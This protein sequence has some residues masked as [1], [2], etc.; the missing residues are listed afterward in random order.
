[1]ILH[2]LNLANYRA[3]EQIEIEF[4]SDVTVIAGVNGVG[5]S[6]IL[7]AIAVM[8]SRALPE[9][10]EA[11]SNIARSF[12]DDD[13][14]V[15]KPS[16]EVSGIFEVNGQRF[17]SLTQRSLGTQSGDLV[18]QILEGLRADGQPPS[19]AAQ[20]E[21]R[22]TLRQFKSASEQPVAVLF[23]PGRLLPGKPVRLHWPNLEDKSRAYADALAPRT[24]ELREFMEWFNAQQELAKK[25]EEDDELDSQEQILEALQRVVTDFVPEFTN[26]RIEREPRLRFVVDKNGT[27]LSL[28][29]L[30]DG[31]RGLLAVFFDLT[32]R[33]TIANP[34]R[35]DPI[36]DG[37]GIV[38][39]DEIE[40]HL[41]PRWQR[42][43][44][45]KLKDTFAGCQFILTTHSPQTLGEAEARQVRYLYRDRENH[46]RRIVPSQALGLDSS[47][48]LE[49]VMGA[50][51]RNAR[52]RERL[53]DL[54]RAIDKEEFDSARS[55]Y[56]ELKTYIGSIDPD[57]V[58][59]Q[60]MMEFLGESL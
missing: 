2:K 50:P 9:F 6:A 30:S 31:E 57:L 28:N 43:A 34:D 19:D 45:H 42:D 23:S 12:N 56:A 29:Q 41:H 38:L 25:R 33:L 40:L 51:A 7:D 1:M 36:H 35:D 54:F 39:M 32:R 8:F 11:K 52:T 4:E 53:R 47:R 27:T 14:F 16:L 18:F 21:T 15:G 20:Q 44:L 24:V 46:V 37:K 22:A 48:I 60:S 26:L 55:I 3:F 13:V 10:T 5:K 49:E 58:R 59:A 17:H